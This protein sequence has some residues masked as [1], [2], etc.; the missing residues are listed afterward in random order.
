M[1]LKRFFVGIGI[2]LA[3]LVVYGVYELSMFSIFDDEFKVIETISVPNKNYLLKVYYI[4]SNASSQSYIQV[5]KIEN[6]IE[7]VL[8]SYERYN[9]LESFEIMENDTINLIIS[10]TSQ[11]N[12]VNKEV[13]IK[14]PPL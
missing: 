10:D 6:G 2:A 1:K 8:E 13:R 9:Y 11:L 14:L 3:L 4:P 7:E 12:T 5:R